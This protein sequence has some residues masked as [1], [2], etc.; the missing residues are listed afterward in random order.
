MG[1][2]HLPATGLVAKAQ[3]IHDGVVANAVLYPAPVPT[4]AVMQGYID[5]L[6]A[7]N[8]E[9]VA[10]GGRVAHT[11]KRK[12]EKLV[13]GAIKAW[14]GYVQNVSGGDEGKILASNFEVVKHGTP[15]GELNP[16]TNLGARLTNTSGRV[17]LR[18]ERE[19]GADM[20]HVFMSTSA[21]PFNWVL[22]GATT[23]SR[24]NADSLEPGTFYFFAVSALGAAGESS[25]SEPCQAMAA[26]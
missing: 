19:A 14:A 21:S 1:V 7:A 15:Y 26:A 9:V 2:S 3:G 20:H 8:A 25:K 17:S 10:N 5:D 18:W 13:R 22:I 4:A 23:K 11:A 24:F 16:P 6:A 12:A